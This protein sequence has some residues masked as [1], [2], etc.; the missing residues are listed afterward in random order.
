[1]TGASPVS[2]R[3]AGPRPES[4]G[5]SP[6]FRYVYR[7]RHWKVLFSTLDAIGGLFA[8]PSRGVPDIS[9]ARSILVMKLD[10]IGDLVLTQPLL[11]VLRRAAPDARIEL[12]VGEG[13]TEA[14]ALLPGADGIRELPVRLR[15]GSN[16]VRWG[17][18]R[19]VM[20]DLRRNRP[21]LVIVPKE[22]PISVL[23]ARMTGA[24][25]RLGYREGGLGFL[26]THFV[27][28]RGGRPQYLELAALAGAAGTDAEPPVLSVDDAHRRDAGT[29]L[30]GLDIADDHALILVHPGSGHPATRWPWARFAETLALVSRDRPVTAVVVSPGELDSAPT[31]TLAPPSR[32]LVIERKLSLGV[33]AALAARADIFLGNDSGPAHIAA[34]AGASTVVP[35]LSGNDPRRWGPAEPRG[36]AVIGA[37]GT[38]PSAREVADVLGALLDGR[39][40][41]SRRAQ[42]TDRPGDRSR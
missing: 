14:A 25:L 9:S 19:P 11:A 23:L 2:P 1:M 10:Q 42:D 16:H 40:A 41:A 18:L 3:D 33:L 24:P 37:P 22:D 20:R 8:R 13:R 15:G 34:A 4:G 28:V 31:A 21:D 29:I 17:R 27:P 5:S 30:A 6:G 38:G 35:F 7:K 26:L 36:H 39:S 12:A 32:F